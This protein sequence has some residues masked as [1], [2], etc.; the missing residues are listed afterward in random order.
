MS[1]NDNSE[2]DYEP[3]GCI[4]SSKA[5]DAVLYIFAAVI[6]IAG[7]IV[8]FAVMPS[9]LV[10]AVFILLA[11]LCVLCGVAAKKNKWYWG[12]EKFTVMRFLSKT[13]TFGYDEID[14]V[15]SVTEYPAV[16]VVI[17]MKDGKEYGFSAKANGAKEFVEYLSSKQERKD[18]ENV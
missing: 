18:T 9:V 15:Y 17:R 7:I 2:L 12:A 4:C 11:A 8:Y 13:V 3:L 16:T 14:T 5:A 10:F 1:S 6:V